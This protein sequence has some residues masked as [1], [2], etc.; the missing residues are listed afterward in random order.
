MFTKSNLEW[1]HNFGK[2][3]NDITNG[4]CKPGSHTFGSE[5]YNPATGNWDFPALSDDKIQKDWLD[6]FSTVFSQMV[7]EVIRC[8]MAA[9]SGTHIFTNP[10]KELSITAQ[11]FAD[12]ILELIDLQSK[13]NCV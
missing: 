11:K 9:N 4:I 10:Y 3:F 6:R 8:K 2:E 1:I 12:L 13:N 7:I 5:F